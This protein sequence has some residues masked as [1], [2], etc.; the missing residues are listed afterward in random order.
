M[1]PSTDGLA[2]SARTDSSGVRLKLQ[3]RATMPLHRQSASAA[4]ACA[5]DQAAEPAPTAPVAAADEAWL[6]SFPLIVHSH[7]RWDFVWQ[8]PQQILSRLAANH[9]VLFIEEPMAGDAPGLDVSEPVANVVRVVPRLPA[10]CLGDADR[11]AKTILPLVQ[12]ALRD[13]PLM[14]GRF[15][16]PVQ[17]FYSPMTA[18]VLLGAFGARG[19]VYDCMDEL[20]NFR[21]APTDIG[22]RERFLL[23]RADVVFTGG[24]QLFEAKSRAHDNVHFFGCGVDVAHFGRARDAD[25]PVSPALAELQRPLLGYFGVIDERLDYPLI[26]ALAERFPDAT[27]V[28][29][30]PL[31]KVEREQ[32]PAHANIRWLGQRDYQELPALVKGFDVCLM[33]FAL[34]EATRYINPTK[35]LEYLAA[36]KPVVSTAVPDVVC[37]FGEVVQVADDADA[38]VAAVRACLQKAEPE[39]RA[40]GI[41][42]SEA[43]TWDATVAAM[44][45]HVQ[46]GVR[47]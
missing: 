34:N 32:L 10:P 37:N 17:W 14:A 3:A 1:K 19:V 16:Q 7:L 31:A 40:R 38:F 12:Q 39:R 13:H 29:A 24:R 27:V 33:P 18:P 8:R 45:G 35:T 42:R 28:L 43:A 36:G 23:A 11:E 44:R 20:A 15:G 9:P 41:E 22:V 21:F 2:N 25:L 6:Q 47:P 26:A 5:L 4:A 46:A 30:G